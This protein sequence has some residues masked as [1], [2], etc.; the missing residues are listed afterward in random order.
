MGSIAGTAAISQKRG[1]AAISALISALT[2]VDPSSVV[3][4]GHRQRLLSAKAVMRLSR[5]RSDQT[6][7]RDSVGA[8]AEG[9]AI[10]KI[11]TPPRRPGPA[12]RPLQPWMALRRRRAPRGSGK[13]ILTLV[14]LAGFADKRHR[15][16]TSYPKR[17]L[18]PPVQ[19]DAWRQSRD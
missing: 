14:A 10:E 9:L 18:E 11:S 12:L 7:D 6:Y 16:V 8:R 15:S 5:L 19:G 17:R 4:E 2:A 3:P 1:E 13:M